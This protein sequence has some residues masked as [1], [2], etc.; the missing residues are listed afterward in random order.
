[1]E[2]KNGSYFDGGYLEY[3]GY[4]LAISFVTSITCGI[5]FPWMQCWYRKWV[6]QH[7]VINGR[8]LKFTGDGTALFGKYIIWMLLTIVTCGIYIFWADI[9]LQKWMIEHTCFE[10]ETEVGS[11]FDGD[12]GGYFGIVVLSV[13]AALVPFVGP[14]WSSIIT[15]R[16][17]VNHTV[18]NSHRVHFTGGVG[19]LFVKYLIWG[20]LSIITLGIYALFVPVKY[21]RWETENYALEN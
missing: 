18:L 8:R 10:D 14:A 6:C 11:Y 13:L 17:F 9:N 19:D 2:K 4:S 21:I 20:L 12:V 16:W 5:A 3:I 7:T 15:T 1:M